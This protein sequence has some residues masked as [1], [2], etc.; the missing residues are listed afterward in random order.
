VAGVIR[1]GY[2]IRGEVLRPAIVAVAA[3]ENQGVPS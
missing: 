2:M 1:Q 3:F